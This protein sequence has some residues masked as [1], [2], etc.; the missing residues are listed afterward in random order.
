MNDRKT[1]WEN[2]YTNN[3]P[4]QVSWYQEEPTLSLNLIRS[5]G[6][7]HDA[8]IIDVGGGAST[9]VDHLC[10]EGYT[11]VG[12][13]DVSAQA[14]GLAT[15]RLAERASTVEWY[16]A[17]ITTFEPPHRFSLWHD[18]AVFHFLSNSDDRDKYRCVLNKAL[19]PGG[20]LI[21]M[22]FGLGGPQKCSG[23]D[24]VQYDADKITMELGPGFD[25]LETGHETHVTPS[26]NKQ[27]FA[28]FHYKKCG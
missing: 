14:L 5:I 28:F 10:D 2:V 20:H 13:L 15:E 11:G 9:L 16:E 12:V 17:D 24:I 7:A 22:A 19:E 23:L 4:R 18:R 27:K 25:L 26:G 21:I 3:P 8:F 1:H 6:L